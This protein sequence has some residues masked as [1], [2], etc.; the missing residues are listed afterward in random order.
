MDTCTLILR[1]STNDIL[2]V[3]GTHSWTHQCDLGHHRCLS[4][5]LNYV[6]T[7]NVGCAMSKISEGSYLTKLSDSRL[8]CY[9]EVLLS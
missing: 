6:K 5:S 4:S 9:I 2:H 7:K 8:H 3:I 1:V